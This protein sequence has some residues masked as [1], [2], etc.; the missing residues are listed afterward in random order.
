MGEVQHQLGAL[1][2]A[3]DLA[4]AQGQQLQHLLWQ[5]LA[6]HGACIILYMSFV[7]VH[8]SVNGRNG[9]LSIHG[10]GQP[11]P[12]CVAEVP[13]P[14]LLLWLWVKLNSAKR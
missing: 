4:F 14:S 1:L 12:T 3:C 13:V 8:G 5:Q 7:R 11:G 9:R 6:H 10:Y 2:C